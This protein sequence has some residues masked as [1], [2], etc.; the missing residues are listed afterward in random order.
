MPFEPLFQ[1]SV[2]LAPHA[3]QVF[4]N[5]SKA[6]IGFAYFATA[7]NNRRLSFGAGYTNSSGAT[8]TI[9]VQGW[10]YRN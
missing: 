8:E 2:F 9:T 1:N 7:A 10:Y 3:G 5:L 6:F 4:N